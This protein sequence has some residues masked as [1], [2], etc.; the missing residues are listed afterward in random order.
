MQENIPD[1]QQVS[2]SNIFGT[3]TNA[4]QALLSSTQ[5]ITAD[6]TQESDN[7]TQAQRN[8]HLEEIQ[9]YNELLESSIFCSAERVLLSE[10]ED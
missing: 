4:T 7:A 9:C 10:A 8:L 6:V 2:Y 3:R 1:N 5:L